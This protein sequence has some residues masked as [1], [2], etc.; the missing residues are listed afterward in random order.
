MLTLNGELQKYQKQIN[1]VRAAF[2]WLADGNKEAAAALIFIKGNYK[3]SADIMT[4]LKVNRIR[5]QALAD[6]FK[7]ESPD[8]GGYHMGVTYILSRMKGYKNSLETVKIDEL[9]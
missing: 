5:G 9:R 6:L 8:G 3:Q 7:N 4:W 1:A 2:E